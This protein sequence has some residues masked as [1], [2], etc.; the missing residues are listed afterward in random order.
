MVL[1]LA[2]V[3]LVWGQETH[4]LDPGTD[5]I[6]AKLDDGTVYEGDILELAEGTFIETDTVRTPFALTIR[7]AEGATVKWY[8][9]DSIDALYAGGDLTLENIIFETDTT[10]EWEMLVDT[11]ISTHNNNIAISNRT[12]DINIKVDHCQFIGFGHGIVADEDW[13]QS[14]QPIDSLVVTNSLFYGGPRFK[15][16]RGMRT[17]YGMVHVLIV[18]NNTFWKLESENMLIYGS[19][20]TGQEEWFS[21]LVE[22]NTFVD[23]GFPGHELYLSTVDSTWLGLTEP[24]KNGVGFYLKYTSNNDTLRDNIFYDI[25]DFS[26][27]L[28]SGLFE[29]TY[30]D[31][32]TSDSSGWGCGVCAD[33]H[34][35]HGDLGTYNIA[36]NG[37]L[38]MADPDNGNFT[39]G[40]GSVAIGA[41]HDGSDQG[42][43]ITV[44]KPGT[45]DHTTSVVDAPGIPAAF[46]LRQNYPNP[47]NPTTSIAYA[48]LVSG[49]VT[50]D[51]YNL[52]GQKVRTLT[53]AVHT[54]GDYT[55]VWDGMDDHGNMVSGGVYFYGLQAGTTVETRKMVLLK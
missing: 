22:H 6:S 49:P 42:S 36:S 30:M 11:L 1:C 27:K 32:N 7:G 31:Y 41:A 33:W 50:L 16:Y 17:D 13:P 18:R 51:I 3:A 9:A 45:W 19:D 8:V 55:L 2:G 47:F 21:A 39:L 46:V 14:F 5:V 37:V 52:L 23:A 40:T 38:L 12:A 26:V 4:Q 24:T 20:V 44:W 48:V 43:S 35:S 29:E 34:Y 15:M 10:T 54:P 28:K 53:H 25:A